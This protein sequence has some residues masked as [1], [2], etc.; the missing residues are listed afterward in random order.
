MRN[1]EAQSLKQVEFFGVIL[2]NVLVNILGFLVLWA[3][4]FGIK[5]EL[6][7]PTPSHSIWFH[8]CGEAGAAGPHKGG[9][10]LAQDSRVLLRNPIVRESDSQAV[11]RLQPGMRVRANA[12]DCV[13]PSQG[14]ILRSVRGPRG[15]LRE[16]DLFI[17][18]LLVQVYW[19][20]E[21]I[22][23]ERPCAMGV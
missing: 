20:I 5:V 21:M 23:V 14:V 18:H 6:P 15:G 12:G 8:K 4:L 2:V 1:P 17:D 22:V 16:R 13:L 19:I 11:T 10:F 9:P 7:L 3:P